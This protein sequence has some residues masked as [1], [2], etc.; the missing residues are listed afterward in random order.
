MKKQIFLYFPDRSIKQYTT[1]DLSDS[2]YE[3]VKEIL[4]LTA[5]QAVQIVDL[6]G[7]RLLF[8][9]IPFQMEEWE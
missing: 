1:V 3:I 2:S 9:G 4:P 7:N 6:E 5:I 8:S